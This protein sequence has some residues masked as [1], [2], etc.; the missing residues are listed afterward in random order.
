M[1]VLGLHTFAIASEWIA[2]DAMDYVP[3]LKEHGVRLVEVPLLRP[4]DVDVAGTRAVCERH[5]IEV[6]CSL[7]LP[8]HFDVATQLDDVLAFLAVA[9]DA[10]A[11][12]GSSVLSGVTY[13]TI[14]KTSGK[15]PTQ[16]EKDAV[17][18]LIDRAAAAARAR[19]LRLGI[20]PCNRYET[21]LMNTAA[22]AVEA[23]ERSGADNV[24]IHLDTYHMNIEEAGMAAG[25]RAA[26]AHLGYVHVSES[27]RGVPGTGTI[28]WDDVMAGLR[29]VGFEGPVVLESFNHMHPDIAS[30]LAVWKPVAENP[31]DVV[32]VGLP[33]LRQA[34]ARAG[35]AL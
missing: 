28:D 26:G 13:G 17:V 2:E 14:G 15:P 1:A 11:A 6:S 30:G 31:D 20:E 22:D 25:F 8:A 35:F 5:G 12:M 33:F 21:H 9:F 32:N 23:I 7:G 18:R 34:A 3:A 24:V 29:E 10:A 16:A 27:N 19:G 4:D